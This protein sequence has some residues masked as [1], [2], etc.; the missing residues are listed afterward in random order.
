MNFDSIPLEQPGLLGED[1]RIR[2]MECVVVQ[3]NIELERERR[4]SGRTKKA[5]SG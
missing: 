3:G 4:L 1:F 5:F 2:P